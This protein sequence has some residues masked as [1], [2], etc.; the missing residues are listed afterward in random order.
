MK[1]FEIDMEWV[2]SFWEK[3]E[4]KL[5]VTSELVGAGYPYTTVDGKYANFDGGLSADGGGVFRWTNGFWGGMMWLMYLATQD[6]KYRK[7][8]E[9]SE[10]MLDE[11]FDRFTWI[12]HDVGFMWLL[13][14]V[15]DFRITGS[16]RAKQR[17]LH[18][19]TL[20]AG[21]FN[22]K[23]G[24]IR[25]WE[26]AHPTGTIIDCMMNLPILYWA[27]KVTGDSRFADIAEIHA[28]K[29]LK[30]ILRQ[31]GSSNHIAVFDVESGE[32][33]EYPKGQGAFSGSS[34]SRGQA[35]AIYGFALSYIYTGKQ[36][37]LDAAKRSAHYFIANIDDTLVPDVDFKAHP[38]KEY[39]D[40][41]AGAA[42]ACGLIEL[43]GLVDEGEKELYLNA[44]FG[45]LKGLEPY[46]RF[47]MEEESILQNGV[48]SYGREPE[49]IIYGDYYLMEALLKLKGNNVLFW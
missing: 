1:K 2:E 45:L 37:Y 25:A 16:E 12:T 32:A 10:A 33:I 39:K 40:T 26:H 21:R 48:S 38:D 19:A 8:A 22:H 43:A 6:E 47:D 34:W 4:K 41:T 31:D 17:G 27:S 9:D 44:A 23:G 35:W 15:A 28:D 14:A 42:A 20:L 18:A 13:T 36:E 49:S 29:T 30:Y 46:C 11:A 3:I 7:L 5:S 24:F